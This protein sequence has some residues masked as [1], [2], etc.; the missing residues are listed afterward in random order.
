MNL[1]GVDDDGGGVTGM[2]MVVD[3]CEDTILILEVSV[4][5]MDCYLVVELF[6]VLLRRCRFCWFCL[7]C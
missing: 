3:G 4:R 1:M 7:I 2:L 5:G 6:I